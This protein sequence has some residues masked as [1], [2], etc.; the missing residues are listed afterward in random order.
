MSAFSEIKEVISFL[1]KSDNIE[2]VNKIIDV[3]TRIIDMQDELMILREENAKLKNNLEVESKLKRFS[4][5]TVVTLGENDEIMYCSKCWDDERKL[6]QVTKD[7][8]Y[9]TCPK[10][11]NHNMFYE[12]SKYYAQLNEQYDQNII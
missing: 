10:C 1:Q 2:M 8:D 3:Q 6:I 11:K 4:N 12:K 5:D 9:Y 7:E